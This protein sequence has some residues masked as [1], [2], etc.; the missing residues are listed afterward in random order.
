[1][2]MENKNRKNNQVVEQDTL[3][4]LL[5][6]AISSPLKLEKSDRPDDYS[7]KRTRSRSAENTT[8]RAKRR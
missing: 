5:S 6:K 3:F 4:S 1:M 8:I 2:A 7:G